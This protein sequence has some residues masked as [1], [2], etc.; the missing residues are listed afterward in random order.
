MV[1][2]PGDYRWS[3]YAHNAYGR[4]NNL[5]TSHP[6]YLELD[7]GKEDRL[8]CYRELF[9]DHLDSDDLHAIR[10]A[11]NQELVLGRDDFKDKI[12]A[13]TKRQTR[14]GIP[15]RPRIEDEEGIY[16]I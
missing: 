8:R 14:T 2:Q 10:E 4:V 12:E 3:S 6:L 13:M 5:V 11:L 1:Q 15:G 9:K 16:Y 7:D